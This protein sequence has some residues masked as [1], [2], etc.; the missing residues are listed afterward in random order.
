[1]PAGM[2]SPTLPGNMRRLS[3]IKGQFDAVFGSLKAL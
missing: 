2:E 3:I 1:M